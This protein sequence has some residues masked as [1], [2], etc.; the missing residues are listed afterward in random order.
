MERVW[1]H[2]TNLPQPRSKPGLKHR[3][4]QRVILQTIRRSRL[5]VILSILR[6][7]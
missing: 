3:T 2:E 5:H 6:M 1:P 7:L 4:L